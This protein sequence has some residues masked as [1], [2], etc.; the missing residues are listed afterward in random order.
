[1]WDTLTTGCSSLDN[2]LDGGLPADGVALVYGEAETGKTSLAI[3]CAV[4][5][6]RRGYKT[7]FV[8]SDSTFSTHRLSQIAY[9]DSEKISPNIIL[10]TPTT[11]EEQGQVIGHLD[12]Y[13]SKK[14]GLV[15][16]DTITSLYR[17]EL[18]GAKETFKL[19]RELNRQVASLAQIA[20]TKKVGVLMTSQ[21]R[22]VFSAKHVGIEPVATR[23]LKFWSDV[24]LKLEHTGQTRVLK[25]IL[26]K[27]PRRKRRASCYVAIERAGIRDY[28]H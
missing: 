21:V 14:F 19:N 22:S 11:F 17:V 27:H 5:C 16:V 2:L 26:T 3:Q 18:G 20:K 12:E 10:M 25:T 9:R 1:M 15:I 13:I 28:G 8:D 6:V 24:V 4:Y 7:F 23:T